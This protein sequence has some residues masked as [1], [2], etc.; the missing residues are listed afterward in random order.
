VSINPF[1]HPYSSGSPPN[2]VDECLLT[3]SLIIF[4]WVWLVLYWRDVSILRFSM[5]KLKIGN[6]LTTSDDQRPGLLC[7]IL[8]W[9]KV[10]YIGDVGGKVKWLVLLPEAICIF[11]GWILVDQG[12]DESFLGRWILT[13][14]TWVLL[15]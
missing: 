9:R 3:R 10:I 2:C 15:P 1:P 14:Y 12:G 8:P 4:W 6:S 11:V 13:V 7:L 5:L